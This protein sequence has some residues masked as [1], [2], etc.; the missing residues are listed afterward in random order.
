MQDNNLTNVVRAYFS[1][2]ESENRALAETLL[3]DGFTFTSPNDDGMSGD[4][5][6][7]AN[8]HVV[9]SRNDLNR[10]GANRQEKVLTT[11]NVNGTT[12]GKVFS[13]FVDGQILPGKRAVE[14]RRG[15]LRNGRQQS[16]ERRFEVRQIHGATLACHLEKLNAVAQGSL[17]G[18]EP[19]KKSPSWEEILR[20]EVFQV[21]HRSRM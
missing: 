18:R 14:N 16:I 20:H 6:L 8:V 9:T 5:G 15:A 13:R 10:T 19:T 11:A 2:Y 7:S 1:A 17:S 4:Q 12:F 3:A 21:L